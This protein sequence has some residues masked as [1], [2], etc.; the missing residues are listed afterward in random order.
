MQDP[1][2]LLQEIYPEH[3]WILRKFGT[4][5]KG[6]WDSL[7][8]QRDFVEWLGIKLGFKMMEDWYKVNVKDIAGNGGGG[9]LLKYT[10]SPH[11]LLEAIYPQQDWTP[12]MDFKK[13]LKW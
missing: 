2:K 3:K 6:Y 7:E 8:N 5:P 13:T 10:G 1:S 4:V 12:L 11:K 9:L